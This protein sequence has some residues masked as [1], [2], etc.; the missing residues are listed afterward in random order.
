METNN[1]EFPWPILRIFCSMTI[2]EKVICFEDE[3]WTKFETTVL[4]ICWNQKYQQQI[5]VKFN[6][7][8]LYHKTL[9][10]HFMYGLADGN[11]LQVND[12]K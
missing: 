10:T 2:F 11:A 4:H 9:R 12:L 1:K 3:G 7:V 5:I 6:E 8:C